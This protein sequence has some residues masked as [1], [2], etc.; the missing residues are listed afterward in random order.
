MDS[1]NIR[2]GW[3]GMEVSALRHSEAEKL[4]G[5]APN[6]LARVGLSAELPPNTMLRV[7]DTMQTTVS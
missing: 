5:G 3:D 2:M 4:L 7:E 1:E 6:K